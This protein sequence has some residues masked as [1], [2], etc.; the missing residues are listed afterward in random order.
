MSR[1]KNKGDGFTSGCCPS[2]HSEKVTKVTVKGSDFMQAMFWSKGLPVPDSAKENDFSYRCKDCGLESNTPEYRKKY[3]T[4]IPIYDSLV[5]IYEN[6]VHRYYSHPGSS[7]FKNIFIE[8]KE[9]VKNVLEK[10]HKK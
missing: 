10:Y 6:A 7:L 3:S 5:T 4:P 9:R 1:K 2:C 8:T